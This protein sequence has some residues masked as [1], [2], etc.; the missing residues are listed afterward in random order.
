MMNNPS[1]EL[2]EIAGLAPYQPYQPPTP[3]PQPPA[4]TSAGRAIVGEVV[5]A[6]Y[7][8]FTAESYRLHELPPLGGLVVV[9]N[10]LGVVYEARTEGLG[11]ISARGRADDADGAVYHDHP[12]LERTLRSQFAALVIGYYAG[13]AD[14]AL[15]T[16]ARRVVYTYPACPP[17]VHYKAWLA[18]P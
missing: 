7:S 15:P 5:A 10:V 3:N 14:P 12:D 2:D 9:E 6:S 11:P 8:H 16:E 17:R 4:P 13:D 18:S 1:D